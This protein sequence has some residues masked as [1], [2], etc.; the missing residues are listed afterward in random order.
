VTG[1]LKPGEE[2]ATG[3]LGLEWQESSGGDRVGSGDSSVTP[4]R[5]ERSQFWLPAV[6]VI[7]GL[8]VAG[9]LALISSTLYTNDENRLLELRVRELGS[10]LSATLPDIQTPLASAAALGDATNGNARK[11]VRFVRPYVGAPPAHQF[12]SISLWRLAAPQ[13]GPIAVVGPAPTLSASSPVTRAF[14]ARAARTPKLSV[15]GLLASPTPGLGY[16]F[17]TPGPTNRF[18]A[19]GESVLPTNRRS[20]L[21]RNAAFSELDYALYLG[22]SERQRDL[23]V[24]SLSNPP[25]RGRQ[26]KEEVPFGDTVLTLVVAP[27]RALAGTLPQRLPWVILG[28]GLVLTLAAGVLTWI[29]IQRRRGAE[30]LAARLERA[31]DENRRLYAKQRNIAQT[32]QHA[33]LPDELPKIRDVEASARFEPGE[34]GV[35]IGGDWYD[36]IPLDDQRVLVVVGDVTGRGLHAA[37]TM[38][39][40]RYAIHAY[41]AQDDPPATILTKLSKLLT[42]TAG[43]QLATVLCA[44]VDV[45]ALEVTVTSAGH[46]PPLLM[47][48]DQGDYIEGEIGPPIGVPGGARYTATTVSAPPA[49]TFLAFTDGLVERRDE[50]L[51]RGLARLREAAVGNQLGLPELLT[52]LVTQLRREPA[53]DDTAIV[54]LRWGN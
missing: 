45:G 24:T 19:F 54:G 44:L 38:A 48:G 42:V 27:R 9:A 47:S 34:Q 53:D 1:A 13:R 33:L 8:V 18:A 46:L 36:V 23:L 3:S 26:A 16:A 2:A 12:V 52:K 31:V 20:R 21:Q 5:R 29:L 10:V 7:V 40:L 41:A 17:T 25:I 22:A 32:L 49:G 28:A 50:T 39:S 35:E 51:D 30:H 37:A 11:F 6:V 15:V 4:L 43:G 14:F